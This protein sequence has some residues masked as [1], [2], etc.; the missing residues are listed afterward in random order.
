MKINITNC[1]N[2]NEWSLSLIENTLNIKYAIN[3]TGEST[4]SN[5]ITSYINDKTSNT[6][7]LEKLT[8]SNISEVL[9]DGNKVLNMSSGLFVEGTIRYNL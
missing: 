3:G 8:S 7:E 2:I 9:K 1:N 5:A 4:I 6:H